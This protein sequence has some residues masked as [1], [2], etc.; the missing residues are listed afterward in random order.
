MG[1]ELEQVRSEINKLIRR[2]CTSISPDCLELLKKAR[3]GETEERARNMLE[4]MM[5]NVALAGE[6]NKPVCQSPGYPTVY[7]RF[8]NSFQIDLPAIFSE[9]LISATKEGYLRP[10]IVHPLTRAN[11]GDNSGEAVPN[12]EYEFI[13]G[14]DYVEVWISF[15]GCGAELANAVKVFTTE[16]L[17]KNFS[18]LKR[19]ILDTVLRASGIPCPPIGL[20]IGIGGQ[21]DVAAKLSRK[22]ISVR[23]WRDRHPDPLFAA[24]EEELLEKINQLGIG[25]AG[26]GGRTTA[27]A[28]KIGWASTHTAIAPVAVNFHCWVARRGG[29]RFYPDGRVETLLVGGQGA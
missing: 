2:V 23:D 12:F 13:P 16:Q 8:G 27:L 28:V 21:I 5:E 26:T 10:S 14:L 3:E 9:A 18:G 24:L 19:F 25:P 1:L 6:V 7:V 20:G 4:A 17:G 29:L 15:K 22:A 11:N